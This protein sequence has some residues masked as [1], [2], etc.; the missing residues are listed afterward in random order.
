MRKLNDEGEFQRFLR[1][2]LSYY[3]LDPVTHKPRSKFKK[4]HG[5]EYSEKGVSDIDGHV[6]GMYA[7]IECKMW[8]GRPST[9]QLAFIKSVHDTGGV[10]VFAIYRYMEG[11]SFCYWVPGSMPFTYRMSNVWPRSGLITV[12]VNP[13]ET[14]GQTHEVFD[15]SPLQ[16]FLEMRK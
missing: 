11:E 8:N 14:D 7:A 16:V 2:S 10:G 6:R 15:C 5:N 4:N 1:K 12:P 9:V 13:F 3:F